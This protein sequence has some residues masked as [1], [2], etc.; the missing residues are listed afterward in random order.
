M[1]ALLAGIRFLG[2]REHSLPGKKQAGGL[3]KASGLDLRQPH[4]AQ[5]EGLCGVGDASDYGS[6]LVEGHSFAH[7]AAVS[8]S[9]KT[10]VS[11][12]PP[13]PRHPL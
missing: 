2:F 12:P 8:L 9:L 6:G 11:T 1:L 7:L 13:L 4:G 5:A 3:H 10:I